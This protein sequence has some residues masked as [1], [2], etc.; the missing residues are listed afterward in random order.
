MRRISPASEVP[1]RSAYAAPRTMIPSPARNSATD[2]VEA[3]EPNAAGYAVHVTVSTKMS[4]TW[5]AS[6][7]GAIASWA[8]S[9]MRSPRSP[10]PGRQL[11]DARPEVRAGEHDVEHEAQQDEDHRERRRATSRQPSATGDAG[12][13][14][15][16]PHH[17]RAH[18]QVDQPQRRV[19]D[20]DAAGGGHRL[21]GRHHAIDDP[22]LA[23]DLGRHPPADQGDEGQRPGGGDREVEPARLGQPSPAHAHEEHDDAQHRQQRADA[24]HRLEGDAHDV[25]RRALSTRG[26]ASS[27]A[28]RALGSWKARTESIFGHPDA[29]LR[30]CRR[31]TS[32]GRGSARRARSS[33]APRARRAWWAGPWPRRARPSRPRAAAPA[34]PAPRSSAAPPAPCARSGP[35]AR[36]AARCA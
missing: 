24:D 26:T 34:R 27:P 10:A 19:A 4:Q 2:S 33:P 35:S 16:D 14:A 28:T 12:Q 1:L 25:H 31:G 23:P 3:S 11:P 20:R 8:W 7:T 17:A 13:P 9:R 18:R 29:E 15:Q 22:R 32:R 21:R 5:L 30:P 6:H 36:A